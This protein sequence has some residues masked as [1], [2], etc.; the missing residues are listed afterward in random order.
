MARKSATKIVDRHFEDTMQYQQPPNEKVVQGTSNRL[1]IKIEDLKTLKP[2][3]KNQK[4]FFDSYANGDEAIVLFGSAGT[5]K[6]Y[7]SLYKG[8]ETVLDKGNPYSKVIIVRPAVASRNQGFLP[9]DAAEKLSVFCESYI[10]IC[11]S[12]F[13]R[14]DAFNRL[15]EQNHLE[16]V[17]SSYL[18]GCTFDN[19]IIIFEEFQNETWSNISTVI[20]R[21]G[22]NTKLILAGDIKQTDLTQSR[23]D[24]TG[25]NELLKVAH[26]MDEFT[27]IEFNSSD[28][29]RSKF[30]KNF[31]IACEKLGY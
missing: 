18:R 19:A 27:L 30:V 31:I 4:L 26:I 6:T 12:L 1:K 17:S 23:N 8:I 9:G 3:T 11:A 29:V 13:N 16:V 14:T 10:T 21:C 28:I 22:K 15:V 20:S 2:L 7:I 25:F 5:G 24:K